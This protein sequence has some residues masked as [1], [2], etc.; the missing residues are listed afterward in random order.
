MDNPP[1]TEYI[2]V[3]GAAKL[4]AVPDMA[5]ITIDLKHVDMDLGP[6]KATVDERS[7]ALIQLA[8]R[9]GI[10]TE[11]VSSTQIAIAPEYEGGFA[12]GR[13]YK[14]TSV[15]R[16]ITIVLRDLQKY[17]ELV[18]GLVAIPITTL[19]QVEMDV[20]NRD[21]LEDQALREAIRNA[22]NTAS[23]IAS[24]LGVELGPVYSV[25]TP[26]SFY[27][28]GAGGAAVDHAQEAFEPGTIE[29]SSEVSAVFRLKPNK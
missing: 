27:V 7:K 15:S 21:D 4:K 25:S 2:S 10:D 17:N 18:Q 16:Q 22:R 13:R 8:K 9:T 3:Q 19:K 6:A 14:G 1:Q 23:S 26:R 12:R 11:D 29:I 20:T 24:E 5:R 28:A